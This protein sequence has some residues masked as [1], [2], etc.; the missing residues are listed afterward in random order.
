MA[1]KG[2]TESNLQKVANG[3]RELSDDLK[4]LL[5]KE[6]KDNEKSET[7]RSSEILAIFAAHDYYAD[8][9]SPEELRTTLEDLGPTYVKIGQIMSS[10]VD[11]LPE[12]F[13]NELE[14]LRSTVKPLEPEV[15][16]AV[17]EN[18]TGKKIEEIFSEFVDEP[19]GSASVG[20]VHRA[21]LLDGTKVVVKVQ[22]PL[23]ADLMARDF[24]LLKKLAGV[25]N[26]F[27]DDGSSK[28][29]DLMTLLEEFEKVTADELDFRVEAET[30]RF[31]KENCIED[32]EKISCPTVIDDLCTERLFTMTLVDGLSLAKKDKLIEQGVDMNAVGQV[33][34][35]NYVHQ[36]LDVGVFHADPHQ[37]NIMVADKKPYWIDF[38]MVGRLS[39][40]DIDLLSDAVL[41]IITANTEKLISTVNSLGATSA[42]T[43]PDKLQAD[44]EQLLAKYA[45]IT[46]VDGIDMETLFGE[47]MDL[48]DRNAIELPGRFTMLFR[49][50]ITIEGVIEDICPELNLLAIL[51]DKMT[52]H[53][54]SSFD[55]KETITKIGKELLNVGGKSVKLPAL[56]AD[57]LAKLNSGKMKVNM[58]VT[59][60]DGP[61]DVIGEFCRYTIL[62]LLACVLFIGSCILC[63]TDMK[64]EVAGGVPLIALFGILFSVAL[65]IFAVR[66]LWKMKDK[67]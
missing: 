22:R 20:Q 13:C 6:I 60:L 58:E 64:P 38:G 62:T 54:K 33:L 52:A 21:T 24:E 53:M 34:I 14:K 65:A 37:G 2:N 45:N 27:L 42:N 43:D 39:P 55:I 35:E 28:T 19:L 46:G 11:I 10:R 67:K 4:S 47:L 15:A 44:A 8:G 29:I 61:L 12:S 49:S 57:S 18:E 17:V 23:I 30:T 26:V 9:L 7:K 16:K 25:A 31:F 50:I 51:S 63:T 32:E 36:V 41:S 59:G 5:A 56:I 40:K 1:N 3:A 48:M 66:K